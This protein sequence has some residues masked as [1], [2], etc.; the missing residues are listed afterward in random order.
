MKNLLFATLITFLLFGTTLVLADFLPFP[1]FR[2]D[3]GNVRI[4]RVYPNFKCKN[5]MTGQIKDWSY[6]YK[7]EGQ[8]LFRS[9]VVGNVGELGAEA[10]VEFSSNNKPI[11]AWVDLDADYVAEEVFSD[12][13]ALVAKYPYACNLVG[14]E[15]DKEATK[16]GTSSRDQ[17][18]QE[19]F[20]RQQGKYRL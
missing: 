10:V 7:Q 17:R 14:S 18:Q 19:R 12:I 3:K 9:F 4:H 2:E 13:K 16:K 15:L 6:K 11:R 5:G 1:D 20:E 8:R